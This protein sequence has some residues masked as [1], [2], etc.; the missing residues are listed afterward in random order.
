MQAATNITTTVSSSTTAKAV[1]TSLSCR[2]KSAAS[3]P[4]VSST[5]RIIQPNISA[6][7][8]MSTVSHFFFIGISP[9]FL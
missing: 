6:M 1:I 5:A 9:H 8:I 3:L 2:V 7:Q 4:P